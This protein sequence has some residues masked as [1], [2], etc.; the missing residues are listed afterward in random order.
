MLGTPKL[1]GMIEKKRHNPHGNGQKHDDYM[2][3]NIASFDEALR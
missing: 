2:S 1:N 3:F